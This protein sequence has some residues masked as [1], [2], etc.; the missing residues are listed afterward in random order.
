MNREKMNEYLRSIAA[1]AVDAQSENDP[2]KLADL[3][4]DISNDTNV[5]IAELFREEA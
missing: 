1:Q 3:L 5:V 4:T 2:E